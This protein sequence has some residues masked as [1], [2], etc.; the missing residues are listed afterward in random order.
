MSQARTFVLALGLLSGLLMLPSHVAAGPVELLDRISVNPANPD[1]ILLHYRYG[2][3][4]YFYS[5]DGGDSFQILCA[6][7]LDPDIG[8]A[9]S[10]H[11]AADGTTFAGYFGGLYYDDATACSWQ[12][13]GSTELTEQW[14]SDITGDPIDSNVDYLITST[15]QGA[16]NGVMRREAG[17]S[18]A[19]LGERKELLIGRLRVADVAGAR[20]YYQSASLGQQIVPIDGVEQSVP[21]YVIRVSNDEAATWQ[22]FPF[23]VTTNQL[24]LEAVDPKNPDRILVNI[25]HPEQDDVLMVSSDGGETF[26]EYLT[27]SEFSGV[28]FGPE[29]QLWIGDAGL[30]I[31]PDAPQGLWAATDLGTAPTLVT[32]QYPVNCLSYR[33]DGTLFVC[34]RFSAGRVDP[35]DGS[36]SETLNFMEFDEAVDC[37]AAG[38]DVV[39]ACEDQFAVQINFCQISHFPE[40]AFCQPY[41]VDLKPID[42]CDCDPDTGERVPNQDDGGCPEVAVDV[43]DAPDAGTGMAGA[44]GTGATGGSVA[45][46]DAGAPDAAADAGDTQGGGCSCSLLGARSHD[47]RLLQWSLLPLLA[48]VLCRARRRAGGDR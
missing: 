31:N 28:T 38:I 40:A 37:S 11:L 42:I 24:R 29:G 21:Q 18:W 26:S 8:R 4:G 47:R 16:L 15:A 1:R 45:A 33:E 46:A 6:E 19:P 7:F 12:L 3:E 32:D 23:E 20:R 48:L 9:S 30:T 2:G 36:F 34:Q 41:C 27:V 25:S 43:P 13:D 35:S 39:A 17:G 14:V 44:G 5:S 22:E 10:V